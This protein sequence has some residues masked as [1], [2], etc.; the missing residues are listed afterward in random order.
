MLP[1]N[2]VTHHIVK[3]PMLIDEVSSTEYYIGV[4]RNSSDVTTPYWRI[5]KIWKIGSVWNFGY[6]NSDQGFKYQWSN[7][8]SYTYTQ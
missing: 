7:R 1:D 8:Y 6:P 3:P 5:Q 4:S 2:Q